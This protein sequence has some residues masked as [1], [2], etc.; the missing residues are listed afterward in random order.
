M[1]K[2]LAKSRQTEMKPPRN[3]FVRARSSS[4]SNPCR[5]PTFLRKHKLSSLQLLTRHPILW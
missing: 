1:S 3:A 4:P 2:A 5:W